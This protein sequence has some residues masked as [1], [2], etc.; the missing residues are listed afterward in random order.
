MGDISTEFKAAFSDV[1]HKAYAD[2]GRRLRGKVRVESCVGSTHRFEYQ[3]SVEANQ[4]ARHAEVTPLAPDHTNVEATLEDW[5]AAIPSDILDED[6]FTSNHIQLYQQHIIE[7]LNR[8]S[9]TIIRTAMETTTNTITAVGGLTLPKM[10]ELYQNF[11]DNYIFDRGNKCHLLV[12]Y[13]EWNDL[14]NIDEFAN[15]DFIKD[16]VFEKMGVPTK[17]FLNFHITPWPRLTSNAGVTTC[18]AWEESCVGLAVGTELKT[19]VAVIEDKWETLFS[20]A[21][22]MGSVLIDGTGCYK[23]NVT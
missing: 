6:K 1:V 18:L 8:R 16:Q 5:Y 23:L 7:A 3:G 12:G 22:S 10:Q 15:A 4:K 20:A 13:E 2:P 11:G 17:F 21:M 9:D 14:S 19:R